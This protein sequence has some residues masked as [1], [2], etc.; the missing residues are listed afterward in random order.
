MLQD[1][2][3][4]W[5]QERGRELPWRLTRDPYAILVSEIMLQQT[6][7]ERVIP[8]Y[9]AFLKQFPTISDLAQASLSDV[10]RGWVGLGYNRR[11][12]NL[13][14]IAKTVVRMYAGIIPDD[15]SV[16]REFKGI[17]PY[18]SRAIPCFAYGRQY[19]LLDTNNKRVIGRIYFGVNYPNDQRLIGAADELVPKDK[20]WEWNQALM[21]LGAGVCKARKPQCSK[22]P[23]K[24]YCKAAES[25]LSTDENL[26]SQNHLNRTHEESSRKTKI[27]QVRPQNQPFVN[28][29][30]YMRGRIIHELHLL[31]RGHWATFPELVKSI[32]P[33]HGVYD[34]CR[35]QSLLEVLQQEGLV[36]VTDWLGERFISLPE[37]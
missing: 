15:P 25:F 34:A 29:N 16:L 9:L 12:M 5:F 35:L 24:S 14:E 20:A 17:G 2:L 26:Y 4:G 33:D 37:D 23:V 27:K 11:A 10:L 3:L 28:T 22:C 18:T 36:R 7:V 32:N 21:D 30:R 6:Q 1:K 31:E 19:S 8:Y 13:L